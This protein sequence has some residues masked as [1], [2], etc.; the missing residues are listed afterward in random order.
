M[1]A[2]RTL[3]ASGA[4]LALVFAWLPFELSLG[5]FLYEDMFYY[6]T[7]AE[8]ALGGRGV[9]LDG[10]SP[11]NGFHPLWE[12]L[13]V[14]WALVLSHSATL[15]RAAVLSCAGFVVLGLAALLD[16]GRRLE[17]GALGVWSVMGLVLAWRARD[18]QQ[19]QV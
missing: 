8:N 6:L 17:W 9:T 2:Y 4:L 5:T 10:A 15:L 11:T 3:F 13:L 1:T 12:A 7:L 18:R 16:L 14:P 19:N